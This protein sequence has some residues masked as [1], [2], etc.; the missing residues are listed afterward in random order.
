MTKSELRQM[1]R[2]VLKEELASKKLLKEASQSDQSKRLKRAAIVY[3]IEHGKKNIA[4]LLNQFDFVI[5]DTIAPGT[6]EI[7]GGVLNIHTDLANGPFNVM[8]AAIA[9]AVKSNN[10]GTNKTA[11]PR[12]V[13]ASKY[14]PTIS[15]IAFYQFDSG[16]FDFKLVDLASATVENS[17]GD[18]RFTANNILSMSDLHRIYILDA[19]TLAEVDSLDYYNDYEDEND[20][21]GYFDAP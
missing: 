10:N 6:I 9:Q 14:N 17:L 15:D 7:T 21:P 8:L 4:Q 11:T 2:E 18:A 13:I 16:L 5:T 1:I 20:Y 12:Y 19:D 3:L